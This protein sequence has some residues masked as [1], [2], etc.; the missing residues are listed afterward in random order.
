MLSPIYTV[1]ADIDQP[2]MGGGCFGIRQLKEEVKLEG[3]D[4]LRVTDGGCR[5]NGM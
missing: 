4:V 2:V 1:R 5:S 3:R